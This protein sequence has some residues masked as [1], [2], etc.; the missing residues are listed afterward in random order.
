MLDK[1]VDPP[2]QGSEHPDITL[3]EYPKYLLVGQVSK[4]EIYISK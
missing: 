4:F 1:Q 3:Q 2:T